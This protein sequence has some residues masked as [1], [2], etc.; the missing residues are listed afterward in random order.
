[1]FEDLLAHQRAILYTV[2][3]RYTYDHNEIFQ[4]KT[5]LFLVH[6]ACILFNFVQVVVVI[7]CQDLCIDSGENYY[8]LRIKKNKN[9]LENSA[10]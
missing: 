6:Y 2:C 3:T 4:A 7:E 9:Y 5:L 8:R 10:I 1:M